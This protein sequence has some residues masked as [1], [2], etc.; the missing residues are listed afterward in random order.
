MKKYIFILAAVMT[1]TTATLTS[2]DNKKNAAIEAVKEMTEANE[3]LAEMVE[4]TNQQ[5]PVTINRDVT[6]T[7]VRMD[8]R[9]VSYV[10]HV[11]SNFY[12]PDKSSLKSQVRQQLSNEEFANF[13]ELIVTTQRD[14]VYKYEG[15]QSK[16]IVIKCSELEKMLE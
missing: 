6:W 5:L 10:Y 8:N 14:L 1:L 11:S 7:Q 12:L 15:G 2:C 3:E 9:S 4:E 16:K 13:C